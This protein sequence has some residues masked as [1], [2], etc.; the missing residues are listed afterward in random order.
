MKTKRF[1]IIFLTVLVL[2]SLSGCQLAIAD[3]GEGKSKDRLIG[4]FITEEY[5]DLFDMEGYLNDNINKL[6]GSGLINMDQNSTKYQ[7][8]LYATLAT[9]EL[10]NEEGETFNT[11]EYVFEDVEGISYFAA[12]VPATENDDSF[13]TSGSD[14][15]ISDGHMGIYNR[16][17]EDRITLDG[18]IYISSAHTS[19]S[20]YVNPV[21]QSSD[22][23]VYAISGNGIL[24]SGDQGEG[25]IYSSTLDETTTVTEN[26]KNTTVSASIKISI[27]TMYPPEKISV[28]Q[29]DKDS[30]AISR[31]EYSPGKLPDTITPID[32]AEYII[33]E[34]H[35][36]DQEGKAVT[37]RSIYDRKVES[38]DTFYCQDNGIC[39]KQWTKLDWNNN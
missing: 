1:L 38:L 5:L 3:K 39:V 13:I 27:A 15:A 20:H 31:L 17:E 36:Y 35:K 8:R 11:K 28:L 4:V 24:L 2:F 21:Y 18:T 26:G 30:K 32:K 10:T 22:G 25:S 6:S 34:S 9:M 19:K 29:M 14:K 7:K 12:R 33:V 23:S 16:D 37:S